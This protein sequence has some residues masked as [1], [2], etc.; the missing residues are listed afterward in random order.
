MKDREMSAGVPRVV[1]VGGGFGG[2]YA[3]KALCRGPVGVTLV[4]RQNY[5]LFQPL[6]YQVATAGLS[7]GEIAM[8][9]RSV[10]RK[11]PNVEVL[12]AEVAAVELDQSRLMTSDG[13][14]PYDHLILATGARHAYFGHD[15]WE[16]IAPG[17]K[18]LDDALEMRR[19]VLL[20]FEAAEKETDPQARAALLTFVVVGAGPT[21]VELAGAISELA[22]HTLIK[23]FR[24][25]DPT[26]ARVLLVEAGPRVLSA[27][28]EAL[29][30]RA[31]QSLERLG[32]EVLTDAAVAH[33]DARGVT[34]RSGAHLASRTVLW[35]AGVSASPLARSLG[36]TLDRVGRVPVE[37][38]LSV[39]GH[40][41]VFVI[42]D[43]ASF[44]H[45]TGKPLPG[46]APVAIQQGT[47]AAQN[48]L[49]R[50]R[51]EATVPF[52]YKDRGTM[53]TIGRAAGV[54][55]RGTLQLSGFLGWLAWLFIHLLFLVGFRNRLAV[56][57]QWTWSYLTY[58]RGARLITGLG[59][60]VPAVSRPV[61][62][63]LQDRR[64]PVERAPPPS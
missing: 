18:S 64:E 35:A 3:A 2:L 52:R 15:E 45:Q 30:Q 10:L 1:I 42:G 29:S 33:L 46:L 14:L 7:P 5:H 28:P 38:D 63:E 58:Q 24:N 50:V 34:L 9:I 6:L 13:P 54:A 12:M 17:L 20:A 39:P 37:A 44:P 19:R 41:N 51:G 62:L 47:H 40:P 25:V 21:G 48:V 43:L 53:A 31:R 59:G 16:P 8:P 23:D 26:K 27:F 22:R 55:E 56:L 60:R 4:D 11:C 32:V 61:T 49:R 36:V 57:L